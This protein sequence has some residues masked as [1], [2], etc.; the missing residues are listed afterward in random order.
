MSLNKNYKLSDYGVSDRFLS[1]AGIY[2]ELRLA[3]VIGQ[4]RNE[5]KIVSEVGETKAKISGKLRFDIKELV[6]FPTVGDFIMVDVEG[7]VIHQVLTRKS[8]FVRSAVGVSEQGQSV[9]SNIDNIFICMSLNNNFNLSRLERYLGIAWDSGA[10]PIILLTKSDLVES[11]EL[12]KLISE[13]EKVSC[14]ADII[15][16]S[17]F[18]DSLIKDLGKY[19]KAGTTSAFIGSSGVGK[20]TLI[21]KLIGEKVLDTADIGKGDKGRHT[22][23]NKEMFISQ[24]GGVL[25]DTPGMRELGIESANLSKTFEDI[26]ELTKMCRFSDCTHMNEPNC[27]IIEALESGELDKRRFENYNKIKTEAGYDGLSAKEIEVKKL[28]RMFKEVGGMKNMRKFAK[29]NY[30]NK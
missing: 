26:E 14:Y 24:L 28:E 9:A 5:Y 29:E 21:N 13:A 3:R 12:E 18:D 17:A 22:T 4:Y 19:I 15:T 7:N 1:Q 16:T 23:T 2:P 11:S 25:I 10:T 27:A 8:V 30:K 6:N 20:S